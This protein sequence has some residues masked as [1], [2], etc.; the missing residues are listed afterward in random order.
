MRIDN[1]AVSTSNS[2]GK[3]GRRLSQKMGARTYGADP[4]VS[5]NK[6]DAR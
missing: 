3:S 2:S 5:R 6:L 1:G 4:L